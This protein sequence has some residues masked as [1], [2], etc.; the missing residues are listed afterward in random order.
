VKPRPL[1]YAASDVKTPRE[2]RLAAL[3]AVLALAS[4]PC[5]VGPVLGYVNNR[6]PIERW[7]VG[8]MPVQ[9]LIL[10][11]IMLFAPA[12]AGI[13]ALRI[14]RSRGTRTGMFL[15]I[16]A[17]VISTLWWVLSCASSLLVRNMS[18]GPRD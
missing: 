12:L 7:R 9:G 3:A 18:L 17:L 2:S 13:S 6:V 10:V 15:A 8:G 1:D 11:G 5:L 14:R 16:S 4:C